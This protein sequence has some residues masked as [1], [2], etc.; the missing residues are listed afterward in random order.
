MAPFGP[1]CTGESFLR[2]FSALGKKTSF[3]NQ[4]DYFPVQPNPVGRISIRLRREGIIRRFNRA[5]RDNAFRCR[6]DL[7]VIAKG[8]LIRPDTLAEIRR[9][10][11]RSTLVNVNYDDFFSRASSNRFPE[12][13]RVVP[14]YDWIFTCKKASVDELLALGA[15]R[16]RYL[17]LGYDEA[18]H[19]PVRPPKELAEK[20]RSQ[21]VFAGIYTA[22]RA[23]FLSAL[24]DFRLAVW[25]MHWKKSLLAPGL[26]RSVRGTGNNR[27]ASG[28][29]LSVILNS[30][31]IALNF[32]REENRD[33]HN[34]RSFE[35]PAC[36]VFTL[37]QDSEEL[38]SFFTEGKEIA[39][40]SSEAE[41]REKVAYYLKHDRERETM[42]RA[43]CL[44][45][46]TGKHTIQD[47]V[48]RMLEMMGLE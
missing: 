35:L 38:R 7:L 36:G 15:R 24:G 39:F 3:V 34:H 18:S 37:S 40:F 29:E 45:V 16:V 25:G 4:L 12:L 2:A 41:L 46:R 30:S 43:A 48:V 42:A 14:L 9:E 20:Y 21:V 31:R 33:T 47:R 22:D 11:P 13:E 17:P 1:I 19:Y 32:L 10:L 5:V 8:N 23:R 6:P 27:L 26:W 44:R 28:L